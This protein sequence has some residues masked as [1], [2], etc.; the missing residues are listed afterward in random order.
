M[1]G[2][3]N[4]QKAG[5]GSQQ[6]QEYQLFYCSLCQ[7]L[8][9]DY[10]SSA[11][12]ALTYDAALLAIMV[13]GMLEVQGQ[14][15]AAAKPM[16]CPVSPWKKKECLDYKHPAFIFAASAGMAAVAGKVQDNILDEGDI[17]SRLLWKWVQPR[18]HKAEKILSAQGFIFDME[19]ALEAQLEAEAGAASIRELAEPTARILGQV[20]AAAAQLGGQPE[21]A[22][23]MYELGCLTGRVVYILDACD[24]LPRDQRQCAYNA[25]SACYE[26]ACSQ[27]QGKTVEMD[28]RVKE[29]VASLLIADLAQIRSLVDDMDFGSRQ[30][31]VRGLLVT[32][33]SSQA[34]SLLGYS[35]SEKTAPR[36]SPW[37]LVFDES[38]DCLTIAGASICGFVVVGYC[39]NEC[40]DWCNCEDNDS[41]NNYR[42]TSRQSQPTQSNSFQNPPNYCSRCGLR[43]DLVYHPQS[44]WICLA[45][46][47]ELQ[48]PRIETRSLTASVSVVGKVCPY[49]Q[50]TIKPGESLT[51][52]PRCKAPHHRDCWQENGNKCTT[53]GCG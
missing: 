8:G 21:S 39:I 38:G 32:S 20:F 37:R 13:T 47:G 15:Q 18:H 10:G 11:R 26:N 16:R 29:E 28:P 23:A 33:L 19:T 7:T 4:P 17:F 50:T 36:F 46:V 24:D 12:M 25:I 49:C 51:V 30:P 45:C 48:G 42:D 14:A 5:F 2:Y 1:F 34:M 41:Q 52:C 31:L 6:R 40:G 22:A 35:Q 3:I 43:D 27:E 44:G 9:N 53:F